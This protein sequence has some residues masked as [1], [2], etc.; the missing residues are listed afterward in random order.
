LLPVRATVINVGG[1]GARRAWA[2]IKPRAGD[3]HIVLISSPNLIADQLMGVTP[4]DLMGFS[5]IAILYTEYIAFVVRSDSRFRNGAD[6]LH[7]LSEKAGKV[8]FA[9]STSLGNTNH[10]AIAKVIRY[11]GAD[12]RAP[13]IRVFDSALDTVADVVAGHADVGAITAASAVAELDAGRLRGIGISSPERLAGI[14]ASCPT[15]AEQRVDCTVGSWRGVS[16]PPRLTPAQI[17]YW[18]NVLAAAIKTKEWKAELARHFWTESFMSGGALQ[19]YL[20]G[21]HDETQ[22]IVRQLGLLS[23]EATPPHGSVSS[24]GSEQ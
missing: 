24:R 9:L 12:T 6:L 19:K 13:P 15:W 11:A 5:A 16:G 8:T 17:S 3:A 21:E 2:H 4:M 7:Q 22:A 14:Y 18:E 1:D 10:V 23:A 20:Q